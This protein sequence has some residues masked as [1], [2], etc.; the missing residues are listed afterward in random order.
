MLQSDGAAS[1][2]GRDIVFSAIMITCNGI[3]GFSII[4][5]SI[6]NTS[7]SF[8]SEGSGAAL[9]AIAVIVTLS[10]VLPVFTCGSKGPTLTPAQL[11]FVSVTALSVYILFLYA[12][13]VRNRE[14]FEDPDAKLTIP[15]SKTPTKRDFNRIVW[16]CY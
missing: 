1:T 16:F 10:L 3:V 4:A 13:T 14:H 12:L 11:A 15:Y 9:S 6:K 8:N 5:A 2:L 7:L